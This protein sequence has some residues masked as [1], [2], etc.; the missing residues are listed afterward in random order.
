MFK[1]LAEL[2]SGSTTPPPS[3]RPRPKCRRWPAGR[4][5]RVAQRRA[6][7]AERAPAANAKLSDFARLV[8][9]APE[10]N[11]DAPVDALMKRIIG[12]V[13]DRL[14]GSEARFARGG[15]RQRALGRNAHG[16][17]SERVPE[18]RGALARHGHD[19]A[20]DRDRPVAAGAAGG[21][22]GRGVRRRPER[23]ERPLRDRPLFD[24][25]RQA[26]AGQERRRVA[27]P[28]PLPVRADAAACRAAR[29]H[30]QDRQAGERAVH[31]LDHAAMPSPT[32][33]IRRIR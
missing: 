20:P 9:I 30:G 7:L 22:L 19:P 2:R 16:A 14:A 5:P 4:T 29:P 21:C 3:P 27:D 8:G 28:R 32:G 25:R 10:V 1:A 13:R 6:A 24:A 26:L 33:A 11:I 17:A 23:R 12:A 18:P 15:G 31:H